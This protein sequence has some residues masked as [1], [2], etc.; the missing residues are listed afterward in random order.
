MSPL[1][2]PARCAWRAA[3]LVA[4][5]SCL[6]PAWSG[7]DSPPAPRPAF[8][9]RQVAAQRDP[10]APPPRAIDL[11]P[12][13]A[14][15][16]A[17]DC[18]RLNTQWEPYYEALYRRGL[19]GMRE[20]AARAAY[21]PPAWTSLFEDPL[22]AQWLERYADRPCY[23][24]VAL[25]AWLRAIG[26]ATDVDAR[27]AAADTRLVLGEARAQAAALRARAPRPPE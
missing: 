27:Q 21:A 17:R 16:G 5:L 2:R 20:P 25:D 19:A 24:V 26:S 11:L 7:A 10:A 15:L 6:S 18:E 22:F 13:P 23:P 12:R 14:P 9:P 3:A 1:S 8:E 4:A